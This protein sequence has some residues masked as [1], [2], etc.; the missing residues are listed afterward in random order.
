MWMSE[1]AERAMM[2]AMS[3][4]DV[5]FRTSRVDDET[6]EETERKKY[7]MMVIMAGGG[8]TSSIESLFYEVPVTVSIV[9]HYEDD[10]KRT[11]LASLEDSFR[12]ILDASI[13]TST[14]KTSFDSVALAAGETRY[15]KGLTDI[16]GGMPEVTDS[17]QTIITNM[18][19]HV[20]GS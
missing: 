10:P 15:F 19:M 14:I 2:G 17:N 8:T 4:L 18:T 3:S 6:A 5:T 7:P 20:C 9:T 13:A 1:I 11:T 16:E 12:K